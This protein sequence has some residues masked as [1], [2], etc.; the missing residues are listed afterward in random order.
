MGKKIGTPSR[1]I[2]KPEA[3]PEVT[4]PENRETTEILTNISSRG[5]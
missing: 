2:G 5:L 3:L 1:K 4:L